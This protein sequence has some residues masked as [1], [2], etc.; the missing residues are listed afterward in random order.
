MKSD[1]IKKINLG[2]NTIFE[3]VEPSENNNIIILR[4]ADRKEQITIRKEFLTMFIE[5]LKEYK[6]KKDIK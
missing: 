6:E 5:E 2:P 1:L 3:I 4:S